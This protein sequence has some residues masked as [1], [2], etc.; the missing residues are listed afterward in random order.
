MTAA[1]AATTGRLR[2][3][4]PV[5]HSLGLE[6]ALVITLY[7]V[8]ELARGLVVVLAK[9]DPEDRRAREH[10]CTPAQRR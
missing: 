6:A 4:L 10:H 2:G 7:G 3:W 8:Y 1:A 5:R 9:V